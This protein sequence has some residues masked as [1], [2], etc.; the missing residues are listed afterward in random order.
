MTAKVRKTRL[1]GREVQLSVHP[2]FLKTGSASSVDTGRHR[3]MLVWA[4]WVHVCAILQ[5]CTAH[6]L[7]EIMPLVYFSNSP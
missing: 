5:L 6:T 3:Y 4:P 1:E 2:S 7:S